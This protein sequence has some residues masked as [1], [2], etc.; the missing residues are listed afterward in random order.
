MAPG[1]AERRERARVHDE[2]EGPT[3]FRHVSHVHAT[4]HREVPEEGEHDESGEERRER[5]GDGDANGV[6]AA[7]VDKKT[8]SVKLPIH[9]L[10]K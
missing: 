5:I 4:C 10:R 2:R 7:P 3:P 8:T 9:R 6:G 1:D